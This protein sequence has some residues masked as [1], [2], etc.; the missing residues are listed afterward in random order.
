MSHPWTPFCRRLVF[1]LFLLPLFSF[2]QTTGDTLRPAV[3]A[4]YQRYLQEVGGAAN[5]Y[6]G[7]EYEGSYPMVL[8][9]PF[10]DDAG[11]QKSELCYEGVTYPALPLAYDLVRNEVLTKSY[12]Q[13]SIKLE[14]AKI[15][16]FR[17]GAHRYV[18]LGNVPGENGLP[19]DFYELLYDGES[20]LYA[21]RTRVI[22]RALHAES[23]DRIVEQIQYFLEK[24]NRF[25][26]LTEANDL[27]A[28]FPGEKKAL[29]SFWKTQGLDFKR[30]PQTFILQTLTQWAPPKK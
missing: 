8:G 30:S 21:K 14:P 6:S 9:S 4:V 5:L 1:C 26:R 2:S 15:C 11:F 29:K 27:L 28:A 12:Q 19:D 16:G 3:A 25:F 7:S 10:L 20:R 23:Q 13:L 18:H 24:G 22:V 17:F